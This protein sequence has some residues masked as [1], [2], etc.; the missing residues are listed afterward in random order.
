MVLEKLGDSL[1]NTLK[2][3]TSAV[4]VDDKLINELA[5]DIQR[6]LLQSDTNVQLVLSLTDKIKE[7][8]KEKAPPGITK[9]EQLVSIVYEEL[10]NFLGKQTKEISIDKRPTK[11]MLV[12]L[13]GSGKTTTA[14]KLAKFYKKRGY[15]VA[16]IQTD[17]YRPAAYDQLE[18][19]AKQVGVDFYGNKKEKDPVNIYLFFEE[20]LSK[21]DIVIVDTAGRDALSEDLISELKQLQA[22]VQADER[23]LVI[24]AD[25]GQAAQRQAEAFHESS[26]VTGVIVTKLEGTAKGGGALSACAV[27]NAPITFIGVGEKIDDLEVFYPQRF[28]GR[29]IGMGDIESLLEKA[30]EVM[31]EEDAKDIQEKF[32]KGEFNLVDLYEQMKSLK[33]MG[34]FQKI[35]QMIPGMG[36]M[37]LQKEMLEV[38]EGKLEKW[39]YI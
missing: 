23:L 18:Q 13:F 27:T 3:I 4:F 15:K 9:R 25:I 17:T 39:K 19:L 14:G 16:V 7:R 22:A 36:Q 10:T 20:K 34:S 11:I 31:S 30:K 35:M 8:A 24:S 29:L 33:K 2:K 28:V 12:G 37:K 5:K 38:Q 21:Y 6:A 1:K 32:L 26:K